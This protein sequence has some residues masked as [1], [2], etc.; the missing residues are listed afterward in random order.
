[1][2]NKKTHLTVYI[3][4]FLIGA[5][6]TIVIS[7]LTPLR[8]KNIIPNRVEFIDV[9][10]FYT[11]FKVNPDKYVLVDIRP[12]FVRLDYPE[13]AVH[14]SIFLL[15]EGWKKLP[16]SGKTIVIFCEED[17]SE[18]L[19]YGYLEYQGLLNIK[20]VKGGRKAWKEAGLP[21]VKNPNYAKEA[22]PFLAPFREGGL[23]PKETNP[24][25]S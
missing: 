15:S 14:S 6:F 25:S 17:I 24:N 23:I 13:N 11:D 22:T 19:A 8:H 10:K 18:S 16:R 5:V 2:E 21:L 4:L 12:E 9:K 3:G 1:M 7:Y 20:A